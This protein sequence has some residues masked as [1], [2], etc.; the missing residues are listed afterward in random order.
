MA[1][2]RDDAAYGRRVESRYHDTESTHPDYRE[3]VGRVFVVEG[4]EYTIAKVYN[5][6]GVI[7][8]NTRRP[9]SSGECMWT[10]DRL[11]ELGIWPLPVA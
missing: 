2:F 5:R 8:F 9:G 4:K 10:R 1:Q 3:F 11:T 6:G 7:V